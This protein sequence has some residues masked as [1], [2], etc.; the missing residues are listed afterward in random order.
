MNE[1]IHAEPRPQPRQR[2]A[3][4]PQVDVVRSAAGGQLVIT[5]HVDTERQNESRAQIPVGLRRALA[6]AVQGV[7][8]ELMPFPSEEVK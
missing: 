1:A 8:D 7:V 4:V 6:S 2:V 5:V 3:Q